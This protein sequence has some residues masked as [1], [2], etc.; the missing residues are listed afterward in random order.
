MLNIQKKQQSDELVKEET[1]TAKVSN[2]STAEDS[3]K[4]KI[5]NKHFSSKIH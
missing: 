5:S 4:D 1:L 3:K 2:A